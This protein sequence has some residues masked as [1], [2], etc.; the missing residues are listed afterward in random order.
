MGKNIIICSDGTGNTF[1]SR[2]TNVTHLIECLALDNHRQ[3]VAVYDQGVG[4]SAHRCS[5]VYAYKE[6]LKDPEALRI[7]PPPIESRFRPK[8]WL[9]R[10][11]GLLFGYGLK[12]NVREMY[13]ELS[14]LYEGPDDRVFL[15]GFSRGAFTVRALAGLLY[16]CRLP[17]PKSTDFNARFKRAWELYESVLE[18]EAVT[19][20]FREK[21]RSCPIHFLGI[22]DTVKS[23]GGLNPVIL[24]H[25]RH[26][27]IVQYVR[28]ALAL[29]EHRAWFKPT[30]WG[31]LDIDKDG[32]MTRL[33]KEDLQLY[34]QQDIDE[35]WFA[36]CHSDIGGGDE[37][38]V[39]ARI[40]LRWMLGEAVNVERGLRLS[41]EGKA[42]LNNDDPP[43][44]PEIHDLWN[45]GWWAVEQVLR[46][47]IDN[48]GAYPVKKWV[49]G[50]N[51]KREPERLIRR[52]NGTVFLHATVDGMS[53][54]P[55]KGVHRHTKSLPGEA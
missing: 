34:E 11:R 26:N 15:F 30:T 47:E 6:G 13:R 9:D 42:L 21:Q 29:Q 41:D 27:P 28:H 49:W 20:P 50:S 17:P 16:R 53:L 45:L 4:T 10:G 31:L 18:D 44:P 51:G 14:N 48:S 8:A 5:R 54:I 38:E 36:G 52:S 24:P 23:Y 40:A 12:E 19:V 25:L 22:W 3:Q 35:V 2:I 1:D 32:A 55:G 7:L 33:K 39:T 37:E 43:G 46:K